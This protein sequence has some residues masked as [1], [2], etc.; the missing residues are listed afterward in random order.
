MPTLDWFNRAEAFTTAARV[1]YRLLEEVSVRSAA[2]SDEGYAASALPG[3]GR[4]TRCA[5]ELKA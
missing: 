3:H 4:A 1:P 2:A 5:A